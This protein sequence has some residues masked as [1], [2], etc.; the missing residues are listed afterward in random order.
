M[1]LHGA[2][3]AMNNLQCCL[4]V[5]V[6]KQNGELVATPPCRQIAGANE[7]SH[8]RGDAAQRFIARFVREL[9]VDV[10]EMIHIDQCDTQWPASICRC[11]GP[12]VQALIEPPQVG[13][14]RQSVLVSPLL[15]LHGRRRQGPQLDF[16]L[17]RRDL[18]VHHLLSPLK[19]QALNG[20]IVTQQLAEFDCREV[21]TSQS[22]LDIGANSMTKA[23]QRQVF[24]FRGPRGQPTR[25]HCGDFKLARLNGQFGLQP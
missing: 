20:L 1:L 25:V 6:A 19:I 21:W 9:V 13:N 8:L 18:I 10:P 23:C 7:R 16:A 14:S 4:H 17:A 15:K 12:L 22:N 24:H 3:Y 5:C 2:L 11:S